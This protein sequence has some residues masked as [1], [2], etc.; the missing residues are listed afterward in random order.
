MARYHCLAVSDIR[1]GE[2]SLVPLRQEDIL[3]IMHWRNA[4][5]DVLRQKAPITPENQQRY[6]DDVIV[7]GFSQPQPGQILFSYLLNGTAI[8]YGGLVHLAWEDKRA[9][10]SFLLNP[11][12]LAPETYR[13]DF[14]C[15]LNLLKEAAF[16]RLG[17]ARLF[18]E[19]YDIRPQHIAILEANG[20]DLEGRLRGHVWINGRPVDSLMHGC[21][22]PAFC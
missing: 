20:F 15:Y 18:T 2:R 10:V 13:E 7:P 9:E 6:Y 5:L 17:F 12:R 16:S 21:L 22:N 4:Q 14:G 19:T 3:P 11:E 1:Q 8:G